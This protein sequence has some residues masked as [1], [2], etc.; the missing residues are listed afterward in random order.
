MNVLG[1]ECPRLGQRMLTAV[2]QRRGHHRQ[3][4]AVDERGA[5]RE[6]AVER[7][8]DAPAE[9]AE[10]VHEI[11]DRPVPVAGLALRLEHRLVDPDVAADVVREH[12]EHALQPVLGGASRTMLAVTIAPALTIGLNGRLVDAS[13]DIELNG[14]PDGSTPTRSVTAACPLSSSARPNTN[15]F[16][17]D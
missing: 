6:V 7:L 10:R 5:L 4:P 12:R 8:L 14:F 9:L 13:T 1:L 15:G 17:I 3:V 2:G 11:G 16:E